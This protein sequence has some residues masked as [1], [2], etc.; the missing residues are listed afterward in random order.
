M[1]PAV[2]QQGLAVQCDAR[3][4]YHKKHRHLA[5]VLV[6]RPDHGAV[7]YR[8]KG[9]HHLL[10][11]DLSTLAAVQARNRLRKPVSVTYRTGLGYAETEIGKWRPETGAAKPPVQRRNS[12]I[13]QPET[14]AR[15]PNP[16][17]C[18]RFSHTRK[19]HRT[20]RFGALCRGLGNQSIF[21]HWR[22]CRREI[23]S[24]NR[25][26]S[27]IEP[28]SGL[29]KRKLENGE[30]RSDTSKGGVNSARSDSRPATRGK[31]HLPL[32]RSEPCRM[33]EKQ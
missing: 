8:R 6:R 32:P 23:D 10:D 26:P 7:E 5:E 3:A 33:A 22:R 13:C 15:Q 9:I 1:N 19:E 11:L 21:P 2:G 24:A 30:Q 17:E 16:R 28:V 25:S 29:P 14:P 18:R 4:W 31:F 20:F 27:H 12:R